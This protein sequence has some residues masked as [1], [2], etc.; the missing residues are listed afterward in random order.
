MSATKISTSHNSYSTGIFWCWTLFILFIFSLFRLPGLGVPLASDELAT[1][2]L[3]AQMPYLKIFSNYQ[4]PNNHIFL[5]L[6]LSFLLKTFGLKEWLLR[7]PLL[8]CGVVSICQGYYL[9]RRLSRNST[10]GFFTAFLMAICEKHIFYSTNARGY[11]VIMVLALLVVN[12][13]LSR[14]EGHSFKTKNLSNKVSGGYAFLGWVGIWLLG[15]WTVPTI[16][17][18]FSSNFFSRTIV[19][20][21]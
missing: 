3:W 10:V 20:R 5:S 21:K 6:V 16:F 12:Y 18:S 4:Y 2:S 1:V 15:T 17:F 11:L 7:M 19:S 9:G 14:L 13:L 8:I